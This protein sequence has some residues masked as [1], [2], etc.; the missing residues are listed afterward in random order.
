MSP[1]DETPN[2]FADHGTL[3][4]YGQQVEPLPD[5]HAPR[6]DIPWA[7]LIVIGLFV[8]L[9]VGLWRAGA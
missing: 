8:G 3:R 5:P 9:L 6:W 1:T 4:T 7:E 2:D